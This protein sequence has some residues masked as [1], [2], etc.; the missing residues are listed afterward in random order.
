MKI[1]IGKFFYYCLK[2]CQMMTQKSS[3]QTVLML[4]GL[5]SWKTCNFNLI[6]RR[7]AIAENK[8]V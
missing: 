1:L 7:L 8:K 6:S 3:F 5:L 4:K 2:F